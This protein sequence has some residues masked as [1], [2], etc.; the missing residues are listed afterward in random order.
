MVVSAIAPGSV[1]TV[2]VPSTDESG[3]LGVSFAT[4]DG[5]TVALQAAEETRIVLDGEPTDF[6]PVEVL[7]SDL[8][9]TAQVE[10]TADIPIGRGFGA[11]GAAT[12][13]TALA[14]NHRFGLDETRETLVQASHRAEMAAGTGQ[15]DVFVQDVGGLVWNTGNGIGRSE[16]SDT[17]TY[18]TFEGISTADVLGDQAALE[19]ITEAG[20]TALDSF[21]PEMPW[22]D[23]LDISWRFAAGTGLVTEQ[24]VETV[25]AV[26]E[27]GG[28]ATMAMVGETVIGSGETDVLPETTAIT[29]SGARILDD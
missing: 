23:W 24:V 21:D 14:A 4:Q 27:A 8:D 13:A 17:I 1:T 9:L 25:D 16:R 26:R 3:S 18:A 11:S 6:E 22:P 29:P 12:L 7:L 15:G 10:I 19:R 28:A 20:R 2:F 5:V